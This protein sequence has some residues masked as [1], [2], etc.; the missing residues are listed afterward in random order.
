MAAGQS[1]LLRLSDL[2]PSKRR[3]AVCARV[4]RVW[5]FNKDNRLAHLDIVFIDAEG[6]KMYAE[7]GPGHA[8]K[9]KSQLEEGNLCILHDF[10]VQ[11]AKNMFRAVDAKF[12]MKISPWTKIQVQVEVPPNF[13]RYA[14]SL[15]EFNQLPGLVGKTESFV[16]VFGIIS[17]ISDILT[18]RI[19][20]FSTDSLKRNL[21]L[22]D[23]NGR[24]V[25]VALWGAHANAFD[26]KELYKLG[27]SEPLIVLF[28][29][30]LVKS[31]RGRETVSC[32]EAAKLYINPD[33]PEKND[34]SD[35][36]GLQ[37]P[38]ITWMAAQDD[39]YSI[40]FQKAQPE[41]VQISYLLSTDPNDYLGKNMVSTITV[42][43]LA[44]DSW[45]FL[46]CM[47]CHKKAYTTANEFV[48]SDPKCTCVAAA[49]RYK[50]RVIGADNT[51]EA[52]FIFF[53]NV[54]EQVIGKKIDVLTR[55]AS[56]RPNIVPAEI[57]TLVSQKFT[58]NHS[59]NEKGLHYGDLT[60]QVNSVTAV[61]RNSNVFEF[62]QLSSSSKMSSH[63]DSTTSS[64]SSGE[65]NKP[66]LEESPK[67]SPTGV[68]TNNNL[69][70]TEDGQNS[71]SKETNGLAS[72]SAAAT[73]EMSLTVHTT[74]AT[75]VPVVQTSPEVGKEGL[76]KSRKNGQKRTSTNTTDSKKSTAQKKLNM[77][78]S[79]DAAK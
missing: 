15:T 13:P 14:Y 9:F 73:T 18:V 22:I 11:S 61:H 36:L 10:F 41:N 28:V 78:G 39:Q 34:Y 79:D 69:I 44:S 48:C 33:I 7:V 21:Q 23:V 43:R 6:N 2:N 45:W 59:V 19:P 3:V 12:M 71:S 5:E 56:R 31:Y 57:T 38:A 72:Q 30:T 77:T 66:M 46:A 29:G 17:A 8:D 63:N 25:D 49:P 55:T 67:G 24:T 75:P 76:P 70:E 53:A 52:E 26:G 54:A 65:S 1:D 74:P 50:V 16:D 20:G 62:N 42:L 68:T 60:F 32:G 37:L 40:A 64:Q 58:I 4:A 51:G 27:Q 47:G 35:R